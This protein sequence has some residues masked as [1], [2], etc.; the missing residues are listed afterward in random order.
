MIKESLKTENHIP[1]NNDSD[2]KK[3]N[4]ESI[5]FCINCGKKLQNSFGFCPECGQKVPNIFQAS[6]Q[7]DNFFD[8]SAIHTKQCKK[9]GN[10]MPEDSFYCLNCGALFDNSQDNDLEEILTNQNIESSRNWK[11]KW[12]SFFLCLFFGLFGIHKFYEGKVIA[13]LLYM[14][15]LGLFGIGWFIDLIILYCK[16]NPYLVKRK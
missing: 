1:N 16:P 10:R 9:C 2:A 3:F 4:Q 7:D 12:I 11:N 13:G 5:T 6:N 15:T 14:V 8:N